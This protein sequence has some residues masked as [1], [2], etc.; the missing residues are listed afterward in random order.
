MVVFYVRLV[1]SFLCIITEMLKPSGSV[2]IEISKLKIWNN[3]LTNM[4]SF[5]R[6]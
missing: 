5:F 1:P 2:N 4:S 3:D 6:Q